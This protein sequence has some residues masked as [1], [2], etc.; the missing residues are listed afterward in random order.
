[1][2]EYVQFRYKFAEPLDG[3]LYA[4]IIDKIIANKL[5]NKDKLLSAI[6]S[7]D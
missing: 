7:D 2:M 5:E 1:M 4:K 3:S 6:I